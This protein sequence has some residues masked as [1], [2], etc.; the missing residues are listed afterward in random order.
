[1]SY[2]TRNM[3]KCSRLHSFPV[4]RYVCTVVQQAS[5]FTRIVVRPWNKFLELKRAC[6]K[7]KLKLRNKKIYSLFR[8]QVCFPNKVFPEQSNIHFRLKYPCVPIVLWDNRAK[9]NLNFFS[10]FLRTL[11]SRSRH[12]ISPNV[13][14]R[15]SAPSAAS[16]TQARSQR[17][18]C[19]T[20]I[21]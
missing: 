12:G 8:R 3:D 20:R 17:T 9:R 6:E 11:L 16:M 7:G 5:D 21:V 13:A 10:A 1:M 19:E 2:F 18:E 15:S 14:W 4:T